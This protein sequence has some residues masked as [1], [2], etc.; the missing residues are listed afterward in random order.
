MLLNGVV[1]RVP[2]LIV[3]RWRYVHARVVSRALNVELQHQTPQM[4]EPL[5]QISEVPGRKPDESFAPDVLAQNII[6]KVI[7]AVSMR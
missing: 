3:E 7:D 5:K 4:F 2:I 1:R 6:R